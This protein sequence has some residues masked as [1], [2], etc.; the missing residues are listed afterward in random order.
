MFC[1]IVQSGRAV[2]GVFKLPPQTAELCNPDP[3]CGQT[4]RRSPVACFRR[5][6]SVLNPSVASL[7]ELCRAENA[8]RLMVLE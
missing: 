7:A 3:N 8:P 4:G 5:S 2:R 1:R 6:G